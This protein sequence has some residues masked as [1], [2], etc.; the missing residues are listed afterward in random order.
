MPNTCCPPGYIYNTFTSLCTNIVTPDTVPPVP[1]ACCPIGFAYVDAT[2]TFFSP[3]TGTYLIISNSANTALFNTCCRI[4]NTD[5]AIPTTDP[6]VDP[7]GCPCC[8]VGFTYDSIYATC[9]STTGLRDPRSKGPLQTAT[10]P[11]ILSI[12]CPPIFPPPPCVGCQESSGLAISIAINPNVR[13]CT[14]CTP[15]SFKLTNDPH[16][17]CFAPYF[18]IVPPNNFTLD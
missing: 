2:G 14:N 8:P 6:V 3:V 11:C 10:I 16:F 15:Q 9:V 5:F 1:C 12:K 13:G 7:I 18:I 4:V 17:N